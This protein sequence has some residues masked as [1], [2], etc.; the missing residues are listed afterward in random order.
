MG[1]HLRCTWQTEPAAFVGP[2]GKG[3]S[4]TPRVRLGFD[5]WTKRLP[6]R[7]PISTRSEAQTQRAGA[8]KVGASSFDQHV[9]SQPMGSKTNR[10]RFLPLRLIAVLAFVGGLAGVLVAVDV[11]V[12]RDF[13]RGRAALA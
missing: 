1:L 12:R 3:D 10:R 9:G 2:I 13:E 6:T 8:R 11:R 7:S 5:N 4:D